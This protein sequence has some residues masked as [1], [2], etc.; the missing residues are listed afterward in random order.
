MKNKKINL[1]IENDIPKDNHYLD[2][3]ISTTIVDII[4]KITSNNIEYID[5]LIKKIEIQL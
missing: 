3:I 2:K 5:S 4:S 1:Y